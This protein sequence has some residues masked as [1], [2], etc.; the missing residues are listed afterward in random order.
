MGRGAGTSDTEERE[1]Q[2]AMTFEEYVTYVHPCPPL[3]P[4]TLEEMEQLRRAYEW[5]EACHAAF[6]RLVTAQLR[7]VLDLHG[8]VGVGGEVGT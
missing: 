3:R 2:R 4:P 6:D 1:G 5:G 8:S 7:A